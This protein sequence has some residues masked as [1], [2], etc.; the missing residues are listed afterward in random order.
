MWDTIRSRRTRQI[1]V[2]ASTEATD[3]LDRL[4]RRLAT[5]KGG[6]HQRQLR[7]EGK[8]ARVLEHVLLTD[9]RVDSDWQWLTP[10]L[11]GV[12][13][14]HT[15]GGGGFVR[16][17]EDQDDLHAGADDTAEAAFSG[18]APPSR[19]TRMKEPLFLAQS[20]D[21]CN[22]EEANASEWL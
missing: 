20:A 16:V 2:G 12:R 1:M 17:A 22:V 5:L 14:N 9:Q 19:S 21:G 10:V 6:R 18:R 7:A 13:S 4:Y 3:G 11:T 15:S 8:L